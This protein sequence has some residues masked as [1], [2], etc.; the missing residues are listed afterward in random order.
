M[1]NMGKWKMKKLLFTAAAGL[2]LANLFAEDDNLLKNADFKVDT[3]GKLSAWNHV[4]GKNGLPGPDKMPVFCMEI[5]RKVTWT[6]NDYYAN[7]LSQ[8]ISGVGPGKYEISILFKGKS[9]A[10]GLVCR[11]VDKQNNS[12]IVF[13]KWLPRSKYPKYDKDPQWHRIFG[14][15]ELKEKAE[16]LNFAFQ[17]ENTVPSYLEICNPELVQVDE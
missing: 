17:G 7:V 5:S 8:N 10:A 13:K 9:C 6:K 4:T 14:T 16:R 11:S 3:K 12:K 15:F 1:N 2:L